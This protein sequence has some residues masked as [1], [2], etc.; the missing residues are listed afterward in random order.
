[1]L[2]ATLR[3]IVLTAVA[4]SLA[5]A[6]IEIPSGTKV[7]CRLEQ[8]LSSATAD[9]GQ[10]VQM[11]VTENVYVGNTVAIPQG[12][13]V[14]GTI[15]SAVPKRRMGRTGKLDFSIDT[16]RAV[17]GQYIPVR[18]TINKKEGGS[19]GVRTGVL[20]AGAAILFWPAAP[21]FLLMKG[22]D[23]TVN[24]GLTVDV[25]TDQAH[26]LRS[27]PT[28]LPGAQISEASPQSQVQ[29]VSALAAGSGGFA[30]VTITSDPTGADVEVDG[31]FVG[32]T[33]STK[34]LASGKHRITVRQ[35]AQ[36]WE[37]TVQVDAGDTLNL[38]ATLAGEA[39]ARR[40]AAGGR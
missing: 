7:T 40:A 34:R 16:V 2:N 5:H 23:V 32:N 27:V 6:Q 26:A 18:Y 4:A 33:P 10:P 37:R 22:K 36:V 35:G 9:E 19:H 11:T 20:T 28:S 25:F 21:V 1:M 17:D 12:A 14:V 31:A 38:H 13:A 3:N 39:P 24:R 29:M 8:T 30:P 15:I